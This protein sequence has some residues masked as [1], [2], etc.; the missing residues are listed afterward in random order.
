MLWWVGVK[1]TWYLLNACSSFYC[2]NLNWFMFYFIHKYI[3]HIH[4]YIY[5]FLCIMCK[6]KCFFYIYMEFCIYCIWD[7]WQLV[8]QSVCM[9]ICHSCNSF[10]VYNFI[11]LL[12]LLYVV[13]GGGGSGGYEVE[14]GSSS[15]VR[16]KNYYSIIFMWTCIK[17]IKIVILY[18]VLCNEYRLTIIREI[19]RY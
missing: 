17:V 19:F 8:S 1:S 14:G 11:V 3:L 2:F 16:V 6:F 18:F 10:L 15:E 4:I 9:S 7:C 13:G 5:I 12:L